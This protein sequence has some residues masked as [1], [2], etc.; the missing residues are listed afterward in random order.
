MI[1]LLK[2]LPW[3]TIHI[4]CTLYMPFCPSFSV[5]LTKT[6]FCQEHVRNFQ[7]QNDDIFTTFKSMVFS[8]TSEVMEYLYYSRNLTPC[9]FLGWFCLFNLKIW[10][11]HL[12]SS[13]PESQSHPVKRD[14]LQS[15]WSI[16]CG[17]EWGRAG[18][19]PNLF[20]MD[21]CSLERVDLLFG[22]YALEPLLHHL[23]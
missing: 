7:K 17:W 21:R 5:S 14:W 19:L 11:A 15:I 4:K 2:P 9:P 22:F 3:P 20:E 8:S 1:Y 13:V 16:V 12:I 18:W 23:L 6:W 10:I